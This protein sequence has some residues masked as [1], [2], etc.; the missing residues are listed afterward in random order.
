MKIGNYEIGN[1]EKST[2]QISNSA[3]AANVTEL[4]PVEL[5]VDWF[6]KANH[7]FSD[8]E[9]TQKEP[10][11]IKLTKDDGFGSSEL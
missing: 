11:E 4:P 7:E 2:R 1:N 10:V 9:K 6:I 3:L 8:Q 5:G